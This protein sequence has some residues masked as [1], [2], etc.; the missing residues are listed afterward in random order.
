LVVGEVQ[1]Q[2]VQLVD[3]QL[4]DEPQ[5]PV[6]RREVPR[7]VQQDAPPAEAR[8]V[9]HLAAGDAR[10]D[11]RQAGGPEGSRAS[12]LPQGLLR[13]EDP[14]GIGCRDGDASRGDG[15]AVTLRWQISRK[16]HSG[17]FGAGVRALGPSDPD[18]L[19]K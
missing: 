7:D 11:V 8:I 14:G 3:G 16:F 15:Q 12:Q 5:H 6:L 9:H 13:V 19:G 1:V 4:V 17:R 10:R 18:R 2:D